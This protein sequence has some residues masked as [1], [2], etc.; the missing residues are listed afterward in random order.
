MKR[1]E[2]DPNNDFDNV[3]YRNVWAG[4]SDPRQNRL[5]E[6]YGVHMYIDKNPHCGIKTP[7]FITLYNQQ[8]TQFTLKLYRI[9]TIYLF[10]S[11]FAVMATKN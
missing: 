8:N 3:W 10:L 9:G 4:S 5:N 6:K 7:I 11:L 2:T 1:D